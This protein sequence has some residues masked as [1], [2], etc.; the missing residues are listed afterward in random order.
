MLIVRLWSEPGH[1]SGLR[2]RLTQSSPSEPAE[3][4]VAVA[5]SAEQICAIV[6]VWVEDFLEPIAP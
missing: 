4:A 1:E 2:A 5:T 3:Q 6:R